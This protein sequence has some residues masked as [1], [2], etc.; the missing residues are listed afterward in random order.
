M[1]QVTR[2]ANNAWGQGIAEWIQPKG[3][4]GGISGFGR[5][6]MHRE[7]GFQRHFILVRRIMAALY[8]R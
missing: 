4:G 8:T 5:L 7:S 1:K 6:C 2:I 3:T